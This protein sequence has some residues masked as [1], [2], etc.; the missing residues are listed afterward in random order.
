MKIINI[1]GKLM[2][3]DSGINEP[4]KKVFVKSYVP[5]TYFAK[6]ETDK[7]EKVIKFIKN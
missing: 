3:Y 4:L 1:A 7:E 5:G 2:Y 6:V